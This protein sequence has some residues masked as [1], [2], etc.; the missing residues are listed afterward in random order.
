MLTVCS[1]VKIIIAITIIIIWI[2]N[3]R[4]VGYGKGKEYY[5]NFTICIHSIV[6]K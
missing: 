2:Y 3:N 4:S 5:I 6:Q 1:P